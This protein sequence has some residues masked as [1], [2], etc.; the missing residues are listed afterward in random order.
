LII[1]DLQIPFEHERALD[2]CI[3]VAKE[4]KV[5]KYNIL[6]AG[7]EV[8]QYF[9]SR[10]PKDP[11]ADMSPF[12]ELKMARMKLKDWYRAFPM[13][14]VAI[15]N[16]G[17]RWLARAFECYIPSEILKPYKELLD[18]PSG[19]SWHE[20]ILLKEKHPFRLI[21]GMGYSGVNGARNAAIDGRISTAIGHLHSYAG[22]S[23]IR[24]TDKSI[25]A[26]NT[27]CLIDDSKFAFKYAKHARVK[28]NL[29]VGV[30]ID[31]GKHPIVV[32]M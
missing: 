4:Y 25:W 10:F 32:P 8:D 3:K 15:S 13:M 19:W 5:S 12:K 7:D 24:N 6:C 30:V 18:A 20:E 29:T 23:Y 26:M 31:D 14:R 16:H 27:G 11:D 28:G 22:V 17:V 2:F 1:S 9:A 21:H